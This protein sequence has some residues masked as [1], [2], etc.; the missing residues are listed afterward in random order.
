[1]SIA[2]RVGHL[3]NKL[4]RLP[5]DGRLRRLADMAGVGL[6]KV[7]V[8][9]DGRHELRDGAAFCVVQRERLVGGGREIVQAAELRAH[10]LDVIL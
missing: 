1:M 5:R 2:Y 6:D 8:L 4:P 7:L 10:D 9:G 3:M